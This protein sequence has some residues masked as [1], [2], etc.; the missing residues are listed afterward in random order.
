M[1]SIKSEGELR[2]FESVSSTC[3]PS[4][5]RHVTLVKNPVVT[6]KA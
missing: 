1:N 6:M 4:D 3:S 5:T 2:L